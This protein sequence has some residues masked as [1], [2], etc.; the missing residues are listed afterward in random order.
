MWSTE[1][2]TWRTGAKSRPESAWKR[3]LLLHP[4]RYLR[5]EE[6]GGEIEPDVFLGVALS[7]IR[8]DVEGGII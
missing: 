8:R 3:L 5:D 6:F 2:R 7:M 4:S 1:R